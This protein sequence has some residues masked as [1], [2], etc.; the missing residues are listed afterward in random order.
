MRTASR[1]YF[2]VR[3]TNLRPRSR[4]CTLRL[5]YAKGYAREKGEWLVLKTIYLNK[6]TALT[7]HPVTA[8]RDDEP[9]AGDTCMHGKIAANHKAVFGILGQLCSYIARA[10]SLP[11]GSRRCF[12]SLTAP[13]LRIQHQ[14]QDVKGELRELQA[15]AL[16]LL[17]GFVAQNVGP[18][19]P[20]LRDGFP[21]VPVLRGGFFVD[22][23][24]V[25]D[26]ALGGRLCQVDLLVRQLCECRERPF[27]RE[28]IHA[29]VSQKRDAFV[30]WLRYARVVFHARAVAEDGEVIAAIQVLEY[31]GSC[32]KIIVRQID[33]ACHN[34][35]TEVLDR[36]VE[37]CRLR[38]KALVRIQR[39]G[40]AG[41][42]DLEADDRRSQ[43]T[44]A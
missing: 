14:A 17:F 13:F 20:E 2:K 31:R 7:K 44:K 8:R 12:G 21:D 39:C 36:V 38:K 33:C 1:S 3:S 37:E 30:V 29:R 6:T 32:A 34:V 15:H 16:E 26:L 9:I 35:I 19:R 5:P 4:F 23:S 43:I 40:C 18:R 11:A 42:T 25:C 10:L 27:L 28:C 24:C 22:E 41:G